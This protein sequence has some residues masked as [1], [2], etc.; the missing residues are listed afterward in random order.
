MWAGSKTNEQHGTQ[1]A[2][3][4]SFYIRHTHTRAGCMAWHYPCS[5]SL[6]SLVSLPSSITY[7]VLIEQQAQAPQ[8]R[9]LLVTAGPALDELEDLVDEAHRWWVVV[10]MGV[11]W[12][13]S[14]ARKKAGLASSDAVCVLALGTRRG[15]AAALAT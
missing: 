8:V 5:F 15:A 2:A 12:A 4:L 10:G 14:V 13:G 1:Q 6:P 9:L 3:P 7:R 11:V